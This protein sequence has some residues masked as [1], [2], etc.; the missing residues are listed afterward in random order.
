MTTNDTRRMFLKCGTCSRTFFFLLN[1]EFGHN[2]EPEERS[3]DPLAG[4]IMGKGHQCGMLWGSALAAGA[5]SFRR[6]GNSDQAIK[7][8][9][10]ST[11]HIQDSFVKRTGTPNCHEIT[12]CDLSNKSGMLK[13]GLKTILGGV[14]YSPCF[15]LAN[16]WAPEA[17]NAAKEG[18][19][20]ETTG[21]KQNTMSCASE[22]ATGLGASDE[23][24]VSVA[25]FAGGLG[26]SGNGCGAL[27]AAIWINTLKWFRNHPG[28]K[29][30]YSKNPVA[31]KILET[32]NSTTNSEILCSKICK[33]N[34]DSVDDHTDFIKNGGCARLI[35]TLSKNETK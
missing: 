34:F 4:G 6:Y 1:R 5:E 8:A 22:V 7:E 23:E 18:L 20:G 16:K 21:E 35:E 12:G 10:I 33:R 31:L 19:S 2:K 30:S 27:S 17:I 32:F 11:Q 24:I 13:L 25:G 14:I 15:N 3:A 9:I 28:E 26:L 29:L